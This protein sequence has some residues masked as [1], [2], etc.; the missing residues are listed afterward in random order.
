MTGVKKEL[1]TL[2]W[3]AAAVL[4]ATVAPLLWVAMPLPG[5]PI[6]AALSAFI[7]GNAFLVALPFGT[8]FQQRTLGLVLSQPTSRARVWFEKWGALLAVLLVL[9]AIQFVALQ[10]AAPDAHVEIRAVTFLLP[11]VCSGFFWTL[12][13]G[14]TIGGAVFSLA[15]LALVEMAS[16]VI[17]SR[18]T[19]LDLDP[20]GA[21]PALIA[22]RLAYAAGSLWLGWRMFAHYE[23]KATGEIHGVLPAALDAV[24]ALRSRPTGAIGNLVRKELRLQQPGMLIAALF[25]LCWLTAMLVFSMPS[26]RPAVAEIVFAALFVSYVPLVLIVCGTISIGEDTSLGIHAWHLTLPVS[27]ATQWG[28]K[29]TVTSIVGLTLG[30]ALPLALK[31]LAP[32][33]VPLP[34]GSIQLPPSAVIAGAAAALLVASFWSVSLFGHTVKASVATAVIVPVLWVCIVAASAAGLR[35]GIGGDWLTSL[36]VANQWSPED[37]LPLGASYRDF[38]RLVVLISGAA[39]ASLAARHSLIAFRTPQLERRRI[40]RYMFQLALL[41]ALVSFIPSAYVA[42]ARNQ[43]A[44]QPVRE[45]DAALKQISAAALAARGEI[46]TAVNAAELDATGLLSDD[47]RRWL[48][49][50]RIRLQS[51]APRMTRRGQVRYVSTVV[52]FPSGSTFRM[53]HTVP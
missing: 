27:S 23:L 46:P 53:L 6:S 14:S 1:R 42:A 16:S 28:I 44:S 33:V 36:M 17:A 31:L 52:S 10:S 48:A 41:G 34:A 35:G 12:L 15:A 32:L 5:Q 29:L 37:L 30:V 39:L 18:V 20:F 19:G 22:V 21:H 11:L 25:V 40:I 47:S 50:S 51:S 49:G 8:E 9:V 45:L 38:S 26:S 2:A 4:A 3:P 43:Y 7:L 13:A 24:R